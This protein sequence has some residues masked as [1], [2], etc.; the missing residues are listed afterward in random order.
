MILKQMNSKREKVMEHALQARFTKQ[1]GK[2]KAEQR[3]NLVNDENSSKNLKNHSDSTK[4]FMCNKY[5]RKKVDMK[6]VQC[7]NSQG[8]RCYAQECRRKKESRAKDNDKVQCAHAGDSDSN[9]M[10]LMA[11]TQS[12]GEQTNMRYLDS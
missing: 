4:K 12:N 5:S 8:F 3:K 7:Y 11:N 6:E 1:S 9:D 2:E 10:L